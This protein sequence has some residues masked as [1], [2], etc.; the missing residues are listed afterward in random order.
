MNDSIEPGVLYVVATPIGHLGDISNRAK[1]VLE[2][3]TVIAAEDTRHTRTLLN[4]LDI[5]TPLIACH[6]HNETAVTA[7]LLARLRSGEA[8]ALVS[9]AGTPL[10]SDPGGH[11]V[12]ACHVQGLRVVPVPGASSVAAALSAAGL[13]ADRY[14]FEGFLPRT[15]AQRRR[16]LEQ[17]RKEVRTV[18]F[19]EAP[20]RVRDT[21]NAL[22]TVLGGERKAVL[23]RE[24]TK[25]YEQ[26]TVA[27]LA[28]LA[29]QLEDERIPALGEFVVLIA[30]VELVAPDATQLDPADVMKVL[31]EFLPPSQASRV[32]AR[33]TGLKRSELYSLSTHG[34]AQRVATDNESVATDEDQSA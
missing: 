26:I 2:K 12:A 10:V 22:C 13:P 30:G 17:W 31:L 33:L 29:A 23:A 4:A 9:D 14:V 1:A 6:A 24:L 11:V 8:V 28:E 7:S 16:R 34:A 19:F 27:P 32:A 20:Q 25:H 15:G 21:I 3:V 5:R 18:V